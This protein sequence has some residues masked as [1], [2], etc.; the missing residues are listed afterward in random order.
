[1]PLPNTRIFQLRSKNF[2]DFL[3][4]CL[5]KNPSNRL[6]A[7]DLL[8]HPFISEVTDNK[9]IR[10]LYQEVKSEVQEIVEELS[11]DADLL[12]DPEHT[13]ETMSENQPVSGV[14]VTPVAATSASLPSKLGQFLLPVVHSALDFVLCIM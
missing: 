13:E 3:S 10:I 7:A 4:K 9:P 1:M 2:N 6:S 11:E 8:Q 12:H 14:A 5:I